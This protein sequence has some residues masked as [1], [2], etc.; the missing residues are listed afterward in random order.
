VTVAA[1]SI[2]AANAPDPRRRWLAAILIA[3]L[4]IVLG[5]LIVRHRWTRAAAYQDSETAARQALIEAAKGGDAADTYRHLTRWL[6][7]LPP[8]LRAA[9]DRDADLS[10]LRRQLER[11]LFGKGTPWSRQSGLALSR[12]I[13]SASL[14]DSMRRF[15]AALPPLNPALPQQEA[16]NG[17]KLA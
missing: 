15:Q 2:S 1:P 5:G 6:A 16:S 13:E 4:L 11:G 12:A 3:G 9:L 8:G 14:H 7:M 10:A 17:G